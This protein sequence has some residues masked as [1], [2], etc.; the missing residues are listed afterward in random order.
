[1]DAQDEPPAGRREPP[2][3]RAHPL[4]LCGRAVLLCGIARQTPRCCAT[5][6]G[7]CHRLRTVCLGPC[8]VAAPGA[9]WWRRHLSSQTLGFSDDART[10]CSRELRGALGDRGHRA[11]AAPGRS[12]SSPVTGRG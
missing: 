3:A 10:R 9:A 12:Q 7:T 4:P 2:A 1:M 11:A 5:A 8:N 6:Q